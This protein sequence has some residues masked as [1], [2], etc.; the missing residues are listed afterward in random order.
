MKTLLILILA[1]ALLGLGLW[2]FA[3]DFLPGTDEAGEEAVACTM[4][5]KLCPDGSYV[6]RVPPSCAFAPC[7]GQ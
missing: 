4:D 1:S 5:A 6:G 3:P 7:P 2:F